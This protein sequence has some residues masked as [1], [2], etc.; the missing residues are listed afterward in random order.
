MCIIGAGL[1]RDRI[2]NVSLEDG[3]TLQRQRPLVGRLAEG[4]KVLNCP[5]VRP[6]RRLRNA[7][8]RAD[9]RNRGTKNENLLPVVL[10][11]EVIFRDLVEANLQETSHFA[12]D[13]ITLFPTE[14]LL[15]RGPRKE[16]VRAVLPPALFFQQFP[17]FEEVPH[18][19]I[20]PELDSA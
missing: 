20:V 14:G 10:D 6:K 17:A 15:L 4:T 3:L 1:Q 12:R 18:A 19:I 8:R 16:K 2:G 5:R 9:P 7:D 11:D 13:A